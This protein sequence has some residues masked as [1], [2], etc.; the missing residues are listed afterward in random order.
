MLY[1]LPNNLKFKLVVSSPNLL[2]IFLHRGDEFPSRNFACKWPDLTHLSDPCSCPIP[3]QLCDLFL[4][5]G[6]RPTAFSV[7]FMN[8]NM[9]SETFL[10]RF[11][12]MDWRKRG[13]A[14]GFSSVNLVLPVLM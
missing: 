8:M 13:T 3:D 1:L 11:Q 12:V 2:T 6:S 14:E 10:Y 9:S 7:A 5:E 4:S